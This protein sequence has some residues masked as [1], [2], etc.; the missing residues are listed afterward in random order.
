MERQRDCPWRLD[1][2]WQ[3]KASVQ[4]FGVRAMIRKLL[5]CLAVPMV[6]IAMTGAVYLLSAGQPPDV[7]ALPG[8][9][10]VQEAACR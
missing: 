9:H 5:A 10:M 4:R 6:L 1:R 8:R 2:H 3:D 7:S